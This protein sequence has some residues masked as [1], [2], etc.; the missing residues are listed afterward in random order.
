MCRGFDPKY[1]TESPTSDSS[2]STYFHEDSGPSSPSE[3]KTPADSVSK[4]PPEP[5]EVEQLLCNVSSG[6][7]HNSCSQSSVHL[8]S[9][10]PEAFPRKL[11]TARNLETQLCAASDLKAI[12]EGLAVLPSWLAAEAEEERQKEKCKKSHTTQTPLAE[13]CFV[14]LDKPG[15]W[16][17]NAYKLSVVSCSSSSHSSGDPI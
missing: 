6:T 3:H 5:M 12:T 17:L 1:L 9:S 2:S 15:K 16:I 4:S 10:E 13:P 8:T 11:R 7:S 14:R